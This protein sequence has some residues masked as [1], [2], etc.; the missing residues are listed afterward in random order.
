MCFISSGFL[1]FAAICRDVHFVDSRTAAFAARRRPTRWIAP[2]LFASDDAEPESD[3]LELSPQRKRERSSLLPPSGDD[4]RQRS[5]D[6]S[7]VQYRRRRWG[8]TIAPTFVTSVD[9]E[10]EIASVP[11]FSRQRRQRRATMK[12]NFLLTSAETIRQLSSVSI[13]PDRI[14]E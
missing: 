14:R 4:D 6:H 11:D 7:S 2:P 5:C 12:P 9:T 3:R 8:T 13:H 10:S 1:G